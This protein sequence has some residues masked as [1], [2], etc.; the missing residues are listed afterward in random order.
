M[1][2]EEGEDGGG[3]ERSISLA[4]PLMQEASPRDLWSPV[5]NF[6]AP[7]DEAGSL[8]VNWVF[9]ENMMLSRRSWRNYRLFTA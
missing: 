2:E 1:N 8:N 6:S 7:P 4:P 3:D 9:V 5:L